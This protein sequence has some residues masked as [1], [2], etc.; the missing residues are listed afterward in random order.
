MTISLLLVIY[1]ENI[2][3]TSITYCIFDIGRGNGLVVLGWNSR[4]TYILK[5]L[6]Q[7]CILSLSLEFIQKMCI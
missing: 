6:P 2:F 7:S 3:F 4:S 1:F 5:I